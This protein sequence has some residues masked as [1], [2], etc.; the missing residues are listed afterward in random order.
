MTDKI[1]P[2]TIFDLDPDELDF[3]ILLRKLTPE[4]QQKLADNLYEQ[5][6]DIMPER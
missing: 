2:E 3:L 1:A 4:Q 5:T 6:K